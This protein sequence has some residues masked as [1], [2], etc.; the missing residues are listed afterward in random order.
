M[1][2]MEKHLDLKD[3]HVLII[4]DMSS[5]RGLLRDMLTSFGVQNISTARNGREAF[6]KLHEQPFDLILSDQVMDG[7]SGTEL[8]SQLRRVPAFADI[9]FIL[10]SSVRDA[11]IIDEALNLGVDDYVVKPVSMVLLQRKIEDVFRRRCPG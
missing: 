9:P 6:E 5:T 3:R 4:D 11:P 1:V 2:S 7:M 8:L 10:V